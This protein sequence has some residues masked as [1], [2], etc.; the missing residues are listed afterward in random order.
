[1]SV[2]YIPIT[3]VK[4]SLSKLLVLKEKFKDFN[5]VLRSHKSQDRQHND[6]KKKKKCTNNDLQNTIQ[7]TKD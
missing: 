6:Q 1:M 3:S 2:M 4:A 5:G 7:Q